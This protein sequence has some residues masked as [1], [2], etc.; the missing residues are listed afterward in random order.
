MKIVLKSSDNKAFE[1][2][3][4]VIRL[5]TT[6]NNMFQDLGMDDPEDENCSEA[7]NLPNLKGTVLSKVVQWC[8]HDEDF[9]VEDGISDWTKEFLQSCHDILL[10]LILAANYLD[11]HRLL[12]LL[13]NST[14]TVIKAEYRGAYKPVEGYTPFEDSHYGQADELEREQEL[15]ESERKFEDLYDF[16]GRRVLEQT[17]WLAVYNKFPSFKQ[18]IFQHY[19]RSF[20][21]FLSDPLALAEFDDVSRRVI[22][23]ACCDFADIQNEDLHKNDCWVAS[24]KLKIKGHDR[25]TISSL[26]SNHHGVIAFRLLG[27]IRYGL[28]SFPDTYIEASHLCGFSDCTFGRHLPCRNNPELEKC[29][30]DLKC[31]IGVSFEKK[32]APKVNKSRKRKV[33]KEESDDDDVVS[34]QKPKWVPMKATLTNAMI[35][36]PSLKFNEY[37]YSVDSGS[38]RRIKDPVTGKKRSPKIA[39]VDKENAHW[40][41]SKKKQKGCNGRAVTTG[42]MVS[43]VSPH[44]CK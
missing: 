17:K 12:D 35:V 30:C 4:D 32:E 14:F 27:K 31:F 21:R 40:G 37:S 11:I 26:G 7:I 18:R 39:E 24:K 42:G 25:P 16:T 6:L 19:F 41:C 23:R 15:I 2:D 13:R 29:E 10:D 9:D 20:E 1:V 5:S 3:R 43:E 28:Q 8:E 38:M 33:V 34:D 36:G 22:L 44:T